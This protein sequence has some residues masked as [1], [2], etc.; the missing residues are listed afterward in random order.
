MDY[1]TLA[2]PSIAVNT[3]TQSNL[4]ARNLLYQTLPRL[5]DPRQGQGKSYE[6][7]LLLCLLLLAR[8]VEQTTLS[9]AM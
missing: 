8:L 6:M 7:V 2:P 4:A 3:T 5:P 9:G 1:T